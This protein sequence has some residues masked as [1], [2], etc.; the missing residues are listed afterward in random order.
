[1]AIDVDVLHFSGGMVNDIRR[2]VHR[3]QNWIPIN[4]ELYGR[5][6]PGEEPK[7]HLI[8]PRRDGEDARLILLP[9][10][11]IGERVDR[12]ELPRHQG[13]RAEF[14]GFPGP[15]AHDVFGAQ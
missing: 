10:E 11:V 6:L 1:M 12:L 5:L 13:S 9:Q 8:K 7:V 15:A 4:Q 2:R 3:R 14:P